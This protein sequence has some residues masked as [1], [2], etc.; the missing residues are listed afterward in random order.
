VQIDE[1][2]ARAQA[3]QGQLDKKKAGIGSVDFQW[4]PYSTLSNFE[5]L[6]ALLTGKNRDLF[7]QLDERPIADIGG[8]DGDLA[9]FLESLGYTAE[10]VD[11]APTNMNHLQGARWL[12]E[13]LNSR[14][15]IHDV[16]LDSQFALPQRD[17]ALVIFLGI[18][19]HLKNPYYALET[20][21]KYTKYCLVSTRIAMFSPDKRLDLQHV[22][23]AYLLDPEESNND[24]TNFWIFSEAGLRRIFSRAGWIVE[25]YRNVGNTVCSDPASIEGDERAFALLRST[26]IEQ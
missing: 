10:L 23:V 11:Y 15:E 22:P 2:Q 19:Y 6:N 13:A 7:N 5:H 12:K 26:R 16:D 1:M 9:F 25:D 3:F 20:L 17:Y 21:S 4:Y 14:V 8:A 24:A 18:L